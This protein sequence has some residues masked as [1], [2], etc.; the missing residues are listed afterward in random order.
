MRLS[1][2]RRRTFLHNQLTRLEKQITEE[3]NHVRTTFGDLITYNGR[4]Y[5]NK[6]Q[7]DK[8]EMLYYLQEERRLNYFHSFT[9]NSKRGQLNVTFN[10]IL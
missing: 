10:N 3:W 2:C 8:L 6:M 1:E 9:S 7:F 4:D 5:L